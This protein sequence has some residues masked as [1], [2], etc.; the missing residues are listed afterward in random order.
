MIITY[1]Q[2]YYCGDIRTIIRLKQVINTNFSLRLGKEEPK[3]GG[4]YVVQSSSNGHEQQGA[5]EGFTTPQH[6]GNV[7]KS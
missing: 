5:D 6:A 3:L 7:R 1:R 2:Q 4:S